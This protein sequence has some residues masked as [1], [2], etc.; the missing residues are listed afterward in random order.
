VVEAVLL[1]SRR[2]GVASAL[3]GELVIELNRATQRWIVALAAGL[4]RLLS[5]E[6]LRGLGTGADLTG[7]GTRAS[8]KGAS[9]SQCGC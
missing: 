6:E 8:E 1:H 5:G 9:L 2:A 7:H 3:H 4:D